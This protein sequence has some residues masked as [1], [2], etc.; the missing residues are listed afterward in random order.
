MKRGVSLILA[1][2]M[3]VSMLAGCGAQQPE[4]TEAAA[5]IQETT[6]AA[7]AEAEPAAEPIAEPVAEVAAYVEQL[8]REQ[9]M[10]VPEQ[11]GS[12]LVSFREPGPV[13]NAEIV[14][15]VIRAKDLER[16]SREI[17]VTD[18]FRWMSPA[19]LDMLLRIAEAE[20]GGDRCVT[21]AALVMLTIINRVRTKGFA[22]NIYDVL[23]T[24]DQF[25]PVMEGTFDT[26]EPT[27]E[28]KRALRMVL[29]GWDESEGVLFYEACTGSS[30]HSKHLTMAFEHCQ[31]R[32]YWG[33]GRS[34]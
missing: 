9:T 31:T 26:A 2:A 25:T 10:P 19:D 16:D 11:L 23:H 13:E 6:Q 24:P 15:A 17:V 12:F 8:P 21:C 18:D 27:P 22:N 7:V 3:L 32:F 33:Y 20:V 29:N 1:L 30:W 14:A 4:Q 28:C 34:K 5:E